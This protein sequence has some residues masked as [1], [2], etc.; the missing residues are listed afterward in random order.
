MWISLKH[1]DISSVILYMSL[2]WRGMEWNY[3]KSLP[4]YCNEIAA[5][6][7]DG[8]LNDTTLNIF[9]AALSITASSN[10]RRPALKVRNTL[11]E[12][13]IIFYAPDLPPAPVFLQQ[14]A[15]DR[16]FTGMMATITFCFMLNMDGHQRAEGG[17]GGSL[18]VLRFLST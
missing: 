2:K 13:F 18:D 16:Q 6:F 11:H 1:G 10:D 14:A 7:T 17:G 3:E 8:L 4:F 5:V 9:C 12:F 15:T